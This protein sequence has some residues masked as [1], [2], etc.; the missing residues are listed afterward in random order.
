MNVKRK[1][2]ILYILFAVLNILDYYATTI[3]F[4]IPE[5]QEQNPVVATVLTNSMGLFLEMKLSIVFAMGT[6]A[7]LVYANR[8]EDGLRLFNQGL[9][10]LN[11]ILGLVCAVN[12]SQL[13]Y[14]L[15]A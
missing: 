7:G 14:Y 8:K 6:V 2:W 11:V 5:F 1:F 9:I 12:F 4:F 3:C 15:T 10:I 13:I